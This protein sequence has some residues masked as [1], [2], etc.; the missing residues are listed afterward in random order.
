M[1]KLFI[2]DAVLIFLLFFA[3]GVAVWFVLKLI[4][5]KREE[6]NNGSTTKQD[7]KIN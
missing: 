1:I 4:D 7:E 3:I 5:K 2:L 6:V